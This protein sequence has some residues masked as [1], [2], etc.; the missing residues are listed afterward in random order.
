[1][2]LSLAAALLVIWI[3]SLLF[4]ITTAAI[5]LLVVVAVLLFVYDL[6]V[7]PRR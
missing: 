7:K 6:L 5:H 4:H 2:L 1:M 3:V